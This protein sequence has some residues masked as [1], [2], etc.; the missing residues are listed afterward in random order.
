MSKPQFD[1]FQTLDATVPA[2]RVVGRADPDKVRRKLV[3]M[4]DELQG[5]DVMPWDYRTQRYN[6]VVFPQMVNWLPE[7]EAQR[8]LAEFR[9]EIE[10]LS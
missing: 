5:A 6:Q 4:L 1:M 9:S 8:L 10:R 3:R 2:K 7:E